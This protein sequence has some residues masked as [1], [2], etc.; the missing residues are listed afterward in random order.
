[1]LIVDIAWRSSAM[2]RQT[3]AGGEN[4]LFSSKMCQYHS[5]DGADGC[6]ITSNKSLTR[7]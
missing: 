7:L 4:T 1:M 5:P 6:F 3:S 2:G